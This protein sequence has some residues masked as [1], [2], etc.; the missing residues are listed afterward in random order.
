MITVEK[1]GTGLGL[2]SCK[3]LIE[4]QS[5]SKIPISSTKDSTEVVIH[6]LNI[7]PKLRNATLA[8]KGNA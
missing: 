5:G 2:N 3:Q 4:E 1:N 7:N 8:H 6:L